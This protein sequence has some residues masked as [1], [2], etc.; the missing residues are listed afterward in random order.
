M[1]Y[2]TRLKVFKSKRC[3]FDPHAMEAWSYDW[4]QFVACRNGRVYFNAAGYSMQTRKQQTII[5][6]LLETLG[7]KYRTVWIR[8]GLQNV[9]GEIRNLESLISEIREAMANPRSRAATNR[10]RLRRIRYL[11]AQIVRLKAFSK[12]KASPYRG[13]LNF[14]ALP[15]PKPRARVKRKPKPTTGWDQI[16]E[17]GRELRKAAVRAANPHAFVERRDREELRALLSLVRGG[18]Q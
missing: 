4:W 7:V 10:F 17:A 3:T 6:G 8:C 15:K 16:Q 14:D 13:R 12:L 9:P 1:R 11:E 18:V 5:R 2:F